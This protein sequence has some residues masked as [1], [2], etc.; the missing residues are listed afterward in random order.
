MS[1]S[2]STKSPRAK[3]PAYTFGPV[4]SRRFG[5]SLGVDLSPE[6]KQCNYDCLYCELGGAKSVDR[7]TQIAPIEGVVADVKAALARHSIDAITLTANGEPTLYPHLDAL[8]DRLHALK[9]EAKLMILSNGSTITDEAIQSALLKL[10]RVKL[11][12]DS[13]QAETFKK[14]DRPKGVDLEQMIEAM[15][16]FRKRFTGE[17]IIEILVVAG[18]NDTEA[19]FDALSNAIGRIQPD[20]VDV[21][22][23]A[24]PPAYAITGVSTDRL[25]ALAKRI[26]HPCVQVIAPPA[27]KQQE[28]YSRE[29]ILATLRRRPLSQQEAEALFDRPTLTLL[30]DLLKARAVERTESGGEIFYTPAKNP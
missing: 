21:G 29:E 18:L 14:L 4:A 13:A 11:S 25:N 6:T 1:W 9:S 17:L 8:I 3:L 15:A 19:E 2:W 30:A 5:R 22:T 20:R 12:L 24:R 27:S 16:V 10:D 26:T 23:L 28:R 7:F